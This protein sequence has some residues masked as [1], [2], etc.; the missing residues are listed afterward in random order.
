MQNLVMLLTTRLTRDYIAYV[1]LNNEIYQ[2][3][4]VSYKLIIATLVKTLDQY[5]EAA[6]QAE[7]QSPP[8]V[9]A[10]VALTGPKIS[11]CTYGPDPRD[12]TRCLIP[13]SAP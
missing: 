2:L 10:S 1:K 7:H 5:I 9:P 11:S 13:P 4:L 6:A 12:P 3:W 8:L